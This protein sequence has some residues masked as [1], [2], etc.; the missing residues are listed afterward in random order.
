MFRQ[1]TM[2]SIALVISRF[3]KLD[4]IYLS[5][6]YNEAISTMYLA[7]VAGGFFSRQAVTSRVFWL[8]LQLSCGCIEQDRPRSCGR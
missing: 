4:K 5:I 7:P 3:N 6:G 8:V 2:N 1:R